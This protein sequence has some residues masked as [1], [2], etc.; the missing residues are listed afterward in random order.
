MLDDFHRA[1]DSSLLLRFLTRDLADGRLLVVAT[2]RDARADQREE[3]VHTLAK[4]TREA[5]LS[6]QILRGFDSGEVARFV[7]LAAGMTIPDTS[8]PGLTPGPAQPAVPLSLDPPWCGWGWCGLPVAGIGWGARSA[9]VTGERL[10]WRA[11]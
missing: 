4:L 1:D 8:R 7:E 11:C 10:S 5:V 6:Q 2:Y 3:F 9:W